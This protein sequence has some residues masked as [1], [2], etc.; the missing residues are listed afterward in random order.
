MNISEVAAKNKVTPATLRYYERQGL[1]PPIKR[2]DS[3]IREYSID[4]LNWIEFIKCMRD[5]GLSIDSL[6]RYTQLYQ[7]GDGTL[8]E[9]KQILIEEYE[10]LIEKQTQINETVTRLKGKI[11]NYESK[12]KNCEAAF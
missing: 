8:Q 5:S 6:S 12:I 11:N 4:D 3:G 10:K 9:R 1:L 2:T 7:Q